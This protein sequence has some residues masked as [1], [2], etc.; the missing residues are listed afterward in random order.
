VIKL[1]EYFHTDFGAMTSSDWVGLT[2]TV[3][4]FVLMATAYIYVLN[5]KNA[6]RLNS[7][8]AIP[9]DDEKLERGGK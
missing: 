4:F 7:Y 2:M 6:K 3:V 1:K 9:M 8:G 5:P